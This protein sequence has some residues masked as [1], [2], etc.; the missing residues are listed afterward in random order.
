MS[1]RNLR[2]DLNV[3]DA[4]SIC[5]YQVPSKKPRDSMEEFFEKSMEF[6][7]DPGN[8]HIDLSTHEHWTVSHEGINGWYIV[9]VT[10][11]YFPDEPKLVSEM[12]KEDQMNLTPSE[13]YF[14]LAND[15]NIGE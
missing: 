12:T 2:V 4:G 8:A 13:A 1:K 9:G 5:K 14:I 7:E 15:S 3:V 11:G 6:L 10:K